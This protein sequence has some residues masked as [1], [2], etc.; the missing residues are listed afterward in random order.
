MGHKTTVLTR[1]VLTAVMIRG[2]LARPLAC[3]GLVD[4]VVRSDV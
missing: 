2:V 3:K 1:R 4:V